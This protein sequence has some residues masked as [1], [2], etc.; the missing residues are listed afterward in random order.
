MINYETS[1]EN[2]KLA[3]PKNLVLLNLNIVRSVN[4]LNIRNVFYKRITIIL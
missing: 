4:L 2:I 3:Y 1:D